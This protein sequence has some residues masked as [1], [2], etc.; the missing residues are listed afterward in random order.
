MPTEITEPAKSDRRKTFASHS[1]KS[2]EKLDV[3]PFEAVSAL[4]SALAFRD[5]ATAEHS[6]RVA[7]LCVQVGEKLLSKGECYRL[8]VAALLHD[9]GKVGVPDAILRKSGELSAD[10]WQLMDQ[11]EQMGVEIVRKAFASPQLA[12]IIQNYRAWFNGCSRNPALR[13]GTAIPMEARILAIADA[14]D[15]MTTS[16]P[17]RPG[18]TFESA[19]AELKRCAGSQFDA[20]CVEHFLRILRESSTTKPTTE[21][22]A[23]ARAV[24]EDL[25]EITASLEAQNFARIATITDHLRSTA[26]RL[27]ANNITTEADRLRSAV[28]S[29]ADLLSILHITRALTKECQQLQQ[30]TAS[31]VS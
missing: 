13:A 29:D 18:R 28:M 6:H 21:V 15:S 25:A 27:G 14:W 7:D 20:E 26:S 24:S 23:D 31:P 2:S 11:H 1:D 12:E 5:A 16:R 19:A 4:L 10:E 9:I 8:E 30:T 22:S 17:W 3:I